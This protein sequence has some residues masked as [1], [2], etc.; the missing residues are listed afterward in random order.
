MSRPDD[1]NVTVVD[2]S[3]TVRLHDIGGGSW[4]IQEGITGAG[5]RVYW[6]VNPDDQNY[7]TITLPAHESTGPLPDSVQ[8]KLSYW[9]FRCG[10]ERKTGG[11]CKNKTDGRRCHRHTAA[12]QITADQEANR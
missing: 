1:K 9:R 7:P 2:L 11:L 6:L 4:E 12:Q 8:R 3:K 10:A 5:L